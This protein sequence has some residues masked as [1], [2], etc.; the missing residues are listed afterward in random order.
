M[1][2][3]EDRDDVKS[4]AKEAYE[5]LKEIW[6]ETDAWSTHTRR[7][8]TKVIDRFVDERYRTILNAGCGNNDYGLS[9][10]A[11]CINLDL[12]LQQ[13]RRIKSAV[14]ADV[15]SIPFGENFFDATMC[16]G[17]VLNYVEPYDAI[18][19]L[20][21]VTR[22][23][24]L[25]LVDFETTNSA[26]LLFTGHW[27]KRVGVIER[28]YAGRSDKTFLFSS[29]HIRTILEQN[30]IC[31]TATHYYH[32]TTAVWHRAFSNSR[33]PSMILPTDEWLNRIPGLRF[34]ASNVIFVC[35]KN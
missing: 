28:S 31:I 20:A 10:W 17:A 2:I 7:S 4:R 12:S 16:V 22:P 25:I 11:S 8:I 15:E 21:R 14:V 27:A 1:S 30:Q 6:P 18:P 35:R 3:L 26:E 13:C 23:G 9:K 34:F 29:H 32:L 19:E 5:G 33:L 24:G